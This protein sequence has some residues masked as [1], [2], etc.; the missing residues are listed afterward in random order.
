MDLAFAQREVDVTQPV[1]GNLGQVRTGSPGE[2]A[3]SSLAGNGSLPFARDRDPSVFKAAWPGPT[4]AATN[5]LNVRLR[6]R[7]QAGVTPSRNTVTRWKCEN[8]SLSRCV[9]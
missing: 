7:E 1:V 5:C 9:T 2:P 3:A 6:C 4:M 8:T